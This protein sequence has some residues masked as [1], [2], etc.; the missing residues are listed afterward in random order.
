MAEPLRVESVHHIE[1]LVGNAKQAAYYYR[2][3]FGLSQIAYRGPETGVR[4]RASYALAQGTVRLVVTSPLHPEGALAERLALHGDAVADIAFAVPDVAVAFAAA[5]ARG[6]EPVSAPAK[7]ADG[8]GGATFAAIAAFGDVT[9]TFLTHD[10]PGHFFL[11][12]WQEARVDE[13]GVGF[14]RIDHVVANVEDGMM[15][16]WV[17]W[18]ER[19]FGFHQFMSFDDKDISTEFSALRSKVMSNSGGGIKMPINEPASGRRRSQIQEY[20]DFNHGAGVQHVALH[21]PDIVGTVAAL[22]ARGVEFLFVP[23]SYYESVWDRVGAI[24]QDRADIER[25][26]ILVD[27][28]DKGYLLQLFT[29]PVQDRPT[30]FFE[31]IQRVGATGFGKGNFRALFESIER[32]QE[33]RGNL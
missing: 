1:L 32:E 18:Y 5:V 25:L 7:V 6:A 13:P 12:G 26:G 10:R 28:D 17:G 23:P 19:V 3:A 30:L 20:V 24:A 2:K 22:R 15:D 29:R 4:D 14:T 27:R 33:R 9:H 16:R 11:P 31:V 21:T 8:T